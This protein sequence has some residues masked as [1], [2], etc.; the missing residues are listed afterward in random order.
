MNNQSPHKLVPGDNVEV[1]K[2]G[3]K[4]HER[5][6]KAAEIMPRLAMPNEDPPPPLV[7]VDFEG[8]SEHGTY[9]AD[10]LTYLP[11]IPAKIRK[12]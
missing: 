2:P 9:P 3:D 1:K 11:P 8:G 10:Q 5:A 4:N 12:A 6:G 7:T